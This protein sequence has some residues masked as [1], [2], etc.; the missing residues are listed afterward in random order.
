MKKA[1]M[2]I[3]LALAIVLLT[4]VLARRLSEWRQAAQESAPVERQ[5]PLFTQRTQSASDELEVTLYYRYGETAVLG[6]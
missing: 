4:P 6:M 3:L 5:E 2:A 1:I